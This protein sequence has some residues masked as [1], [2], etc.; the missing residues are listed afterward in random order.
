M[1]NV[2]LFF[3]PC[4]LGICLL[5]PLAGQGIAEES[6]QTPSSPMEVGSEEAQSPL[7]LKVSNFTLRDFRGQAYQLDDYAGSRA[8]VLA[9]VGTQCPLAKLYAP[10]IQQLAQEWGASDVAF[11]A[12]N[13]N[14]QDSVT[15]LAAYARKHDL[16]L[17]L[18]KDLGNQL[19]DQLGAQ[20]TPEVFLLDQDRVVRYWGRIDDQYGVGVIRDAP[21]EHYLRDAVRQ[22]LAD[23]PVAHPSIPSV[24]CL[25]GRLKE[26]DPESPVTY[27]RDIA[28]IF[29]DHCVDCHRPGEIGPFS[30]TNYDEVFGW[31]ETI[32]EV[33]VEQRMPPWHADPQ[34]GHFSNENR[35]SD[36]HKELIRTW[37]SRGAPEG[38]SADLPEPR[39]YLDGWQLAR[40][41]DLVVPMADKPFDI[42]ATG[43]VRYQYFTVDPGFRDEVW[44]EGLELLPGNRAVVHH[45]LVFAR[46]PGARGADG[47]VHGFLAGY[48]PGLRVDPLPRGFAK[49]IPAGHQLVFQVHYTPIGSDQQDLSKLGIWFA[50]SDD[51]T[52]EVKTVSAIQQRLRIPPHASAHRVE[53]TGHRLDDVLLLHLMPHMHLRGKAFRYEAIFPDGTREI[54]LD[55]PNYDFN[56]QTAYRLAEPRPLPAGTRIHCVAHFDNSE[57]NLHNPDPTRTVGWGD[58]T[59]DEMMIGYYDIAQPRSAIEETPEQKAR[60]EARQRA[61]EIIGR[62]DANGD[63]Q[64]SLD[65]IPGNLRTLFNRIDTDQDGLVTEEELVEGIVRSG[66]LR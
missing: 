21:T 58:Q 8:V 3:A 42:P 44:V 52:H 25:I 59:W 29:R 62:L 38:D 35:L 54:L 14:C 57:D 61:T 19:A 41:P 27:S 31:A 37:V 15:E 34:Y 12:I 11:L 60:Q 23:E 64:L 40:E 45:I 50:N 53:A 47:A 2:A 16:T 7:G 39:E 22:V 63:G 13:S 5:A 36:E 20:R 32:A 51:V 9:F 55:V 66:L 24:G 49:R 46:P 6:S 1:N 28:P 56:W 10:R 17:P 4:L 33:V 43:A 48:V 30:M 65:E 26:P 18:L